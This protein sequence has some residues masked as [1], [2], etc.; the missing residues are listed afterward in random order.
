VSLLGRVWALEDIESVERLVYSLVRD[1]E[2]RLQPHEYDDLIAYLLGEVWAI[3]RQWDRGK[4]PSFRQYCTYLLRFKIVDHARK[5][6]GRTKWRWTNASYSRERPRVLSLDAALDGTGSTLRE[7]VPD[8]ESDPATNRGT[9][10]ERLLEDCDRHRAR[11]IA[12]LRRRA[13]ERITIRTPVS[14]NG[15]SRR[16][17]SDWLPPEGMFERLEASAD[18]NFRTLSAELTNAVE[19]YLAEIEAGIEQAR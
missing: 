11:D 13:S 12:L 10:G 5:E 16:K 2:A 14:G 3:Y 1:V 6:R 4:T 8:W 18:K 7:L 19:R 15:H 9:D 17:V